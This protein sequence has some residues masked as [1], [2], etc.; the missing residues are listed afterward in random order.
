MPTIV[1]RILRFGF[2]NFWRYGFASLATVAVL[3]VALSVFLTLILFRVT[4]DAT[5]SSIQDK[6]DISV[7]LKSAAPE[8][9]IL[10]IKDA[11]ST[12][13]EVKN[14]EYVSKDQALEIFKQRHQDDPTI[15]Q[16]INELTTNPLLAHLNVKARDAKDY[17]AIA[18]YLDQNDTVK[19]YVESVS[20]FENKVVIDRL[21]AITGS[22]DRGVLVLT[23]VLT[24]VAALVVFNTIWLAIFANREEIIIMRLVGAS[25]ALVRGPYIVHGVIAGVVA[26]AASFLLAI[27]VIHLVSPYLNALI[28]AFTLTSYF[29]RNAI[30]LLAYLMVFGVVLGS[31]AS[32]MAIRRYLR[33]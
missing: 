6:I 13:P 10:A 23:I 9:Q 21:N 26:A 28:P 30:F 19:Q 16:A 32:F 33:Y 11:L 31:V 29:Y 2:Q 27:P 7:Y 25:N 20:Y 15:S 14:V 5:V 22:V 1:T 4:T 12:L 24:I 8:D 3:V 17:A 18:Q